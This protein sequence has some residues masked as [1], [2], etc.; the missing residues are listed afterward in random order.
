MLSQTNQI[1]LGLM[2]GFWKVLN[3]E[4]Q[5]VFTPENAIDN[6]MYR[7]I[8]EAQRNPCGIGDH[9]WGQIFA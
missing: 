1:R 5:L 7:N 2:G 6:P 9:T 4:V 3:G 8:R